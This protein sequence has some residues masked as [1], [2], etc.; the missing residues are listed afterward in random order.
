MHLASLQRILHPAGWG[1][2]GRNHP[3]RL[4]L[5][6]FKAMRKDGGVIQFPGGPSNRLEAA[7]RPSVQRASH[8]R[9]PS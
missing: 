5:F 9:L 2:L 4:G 6:V 8:A 7:R 3:Q 1:N